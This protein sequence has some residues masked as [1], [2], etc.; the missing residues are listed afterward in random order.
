MTRIGIPP[1]IAAMIKNIYENPQFS[2][3][4]GNKATENRKQRTG[5][6]QGCPLCPYLFVTLLTVML[7]DITDDMVPAEKLTLDRGEL[8]REITKHLFYADDTIIMTSSV[9]ASQLIFQKIQ[10]ESNKYGMKLNQDKCEHIRLNAIRRIQFENGEEVPT[11]QTAAY[12]GSQVHGNGGHK[13]EAKARITAAWLTV[14]KLDL[15][16]RK[17]PVI[18]R[19]KFRV[20]DAAMHSKVLYGTETFVISKFV[21]DKIGVFQ[22]RI[23]GK[24]PNIKHSFWSH[25]T[26][27]TVM[28]IANARAQNINKTIEV[29]PL[30]LK[31]KQI[32]IEFYGNIIR[33]DPNTNQ[34]RAI[35]IDE[36]GNIISA[37][38]PWTNGKPKLRWYDTA[39]PLVIQV[40]EKLNILPITSRTYFSQYEVHQYII[41]AAGDRK[42]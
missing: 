20:F 13:C 27:D 32:I 15:F 40:L 38:K 6:R 11:T 22:V 35:S 12:P 23:L 17:T 1:R 36:D 8:R 7:K 30:S 34:M 3:N 16:W 2:I 4:N 18:L 9:P 5:I 29:T 31:P 19:W 33:S 37:P 28:H 21:Y 39:K 25:V 10:H 24:I 42:L 41:K 26:N 14:M